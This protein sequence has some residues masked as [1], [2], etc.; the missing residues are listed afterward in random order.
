MKLK[1]AA[2]PLLLALMAM[3]AQAQRKWTLQ[4]CL[5][6]ALEHNIQLQ[7][8]RLTEAQDREDI[9][10]RRAAL[11][12]SLSFSTNQNASWRPWSQS[13]VNLSGGT[14]TSTSSEVNYNGS[15]G[16][17]AQWTVWNGGRNQ[18]NLEK[19]KLTAEMAEY[20]TAESAN[21]IQEQITQLYV[22][23]LYQ[24]EAVRV[25][26]Q[27]LEASK[28]QRDR[29]QEMVDV[30]SL[31]RVDLKQLEAQV[32]QDEYTVVNNRTQ[33]DNYRLQ[34]KQLLEL[35]GTDDFDVATP[36]TGD[37][38]VLSAIPP[39]EAVYAS[40]YAFRPEIQSGKLSIEQSELD[41]DIAR[42]GF[43][44]SVSMSAGIGTSNNSGISTALTEQWRRNLNNS[45]GLTVSVPIFDNRQNRTNVRKAKLSK[46][47]ADLS[48]QD[49]EQQLY[50]QIETYWL[51]ARN[52]QQQ[53]VAAKANVE[54]MQETY[55]LVSEQFR[56]GLKNIVELTTGKNNLL[57]AQQQLLQSKYTALYNLAMLRFYQGEPIRL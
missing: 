2:L 34:L 3:T 5:D 24:A 45:I 7:K 11:L 36:N 28:M 29:A 17:N 18:K 38:N 51:N 4:E 10:M 12:P 22:Q 1:M 6:Y 15:Y 19:S 32:S 20:A 30:G 55:G 31:A 23:I 49:T 48:L 52:A 35:V 39:K 41:I 14:M 26:E 53:Y 42:R 54:S 33:L 16:L 25:A 57:Q 43:Y 9:Q 40:A 50:R 46:D 27:V 56:L 21:T 47:A 37:A 13:Y 44:P 8:N